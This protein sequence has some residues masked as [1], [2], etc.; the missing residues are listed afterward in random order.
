MCL[1]KIIRGLRVYPDGS[2]GS[3]TMLLTCPNCLLR[4]TD[5]GIRRLLKAIVG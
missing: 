3:N 4:Q 5:I 1:S 2:N